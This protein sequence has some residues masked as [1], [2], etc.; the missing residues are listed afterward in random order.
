MLRHPRLIVATFCSALLLGQLWCAGVLAQQA[1]DVELVEGFNSYSDFPKDATWQ[2][3]V[4]QVREIRITSSADGKEQPAL[5]Y[6]SGSD[7]KKPL[8]VALHSWSYDYRQP[9]SIPY[10]IWAVQNDWVFIHPEYRGRYNNPEA[11]ASELALQD[12]LD[13]LEWAKKNA[14]VDESRIYLAGF[15]GGAMTALILAG[16]HP[17]LWTAVSA[18]VPIYNLVDWYD[19]MS[20]FPEKHYAGNIAASCGGKP[21]PGTEAAAECLRRSPVSYLKNARG[22]A[23]QVHLACGIRD[24]IVPPDHSLRAFNDLAAA[25]ARFSDAEIRY[26]RENL[27]LPDHLA[28]DYA[29]PLFTKAGK[30]LIFERKSNN[31]TLD[32]FAGGHDILFNPI[33]F[34]LSQQ[35]R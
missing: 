14:D 27:A 13:A 3:H 7:R 29:D 15:S 10:G 11:T 12:V 30:E 28:G 35:Q 4:P 19:Y 16:R 34:W 2:E 1:G 5:W 21:L 32:F 26:I 18:W 25:D 8:L 22:K 6:D 31:V 24:E 9:V 23:V 17:E 20:G 33:L